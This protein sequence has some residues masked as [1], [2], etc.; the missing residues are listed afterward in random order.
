MKKEVVEFLTPSL[1]KA[2]TDELK[3][4]GVGAFG[5]NF[6]YL[7]EV[8]PGII[9]S[10]KEELKLPNEDYADRMIL[11]YV[12][13]WVEAQNNQSESPSDSSGVLKFK[14]AAPDKPISKKSIVA[15]AEKLRKKFTPKE[16]LIKR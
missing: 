9:K 7:T 15:E 16:A 1:K 4:I 11:H 13:T 6:P 8:E 14:P 2:T 10:F 12:I 3:I 5:S